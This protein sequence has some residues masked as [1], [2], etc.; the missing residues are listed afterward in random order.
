MAIFA[1]HTIRQLNAAIQSGVNIKRPPR[2][3][4]AAPARLRLVHGQP[5][6]EPGDGMD[7]L[8]RLLG[9]DHWATARLWT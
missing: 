7:L 2:P 3:R 4:S 8:D 1:C 9:H 6:D 5:F